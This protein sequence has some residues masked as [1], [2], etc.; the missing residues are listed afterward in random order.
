MNRIEA[1]KVAYQH[2]IYL[3]AFDRL[4]QR[5]ICDAPDEFTRDWLS[6]TRQVVQNDLFAF[7]QVY[8]KLKGT[9]Q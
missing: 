1:M 9:N 2:I 4:V 6:E 7:Q 5:Q 3:E 8:N